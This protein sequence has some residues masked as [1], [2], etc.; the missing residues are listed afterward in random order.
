LPD[1]GR[2]LVALKGRGTGTDYT[3]SQKSAFVT[4]GLMVDLSRNAV[5]TLPALKSLMRRAC[6][7]GYN[8]VGLYTEDTYEVEGRPYFGYLRGRYSLAD[9]RE[10]DSYAASLGLELVPFVQTLAHLNALTKW[11]AFGGLFDINDILLCGSEEVYG[12]VED[13]FKSLRK[14]YSGNR[15]NV[16]M[17]EAHLAGLG[18]YLDAHGYENRFSI[19]IKHLNRVVGLAHK[20]GFD[21]SIW[22]DMFFR[23]CN[24]GNYYGENPVPQ[25]VI[26]QIPK[27][28]DLVYWDYHGTEKPR[29]ERMLAQHKRFPG[30]T[31]CANQVWKCLGLAPNHDWTM[32][33]MDAFLPAQTEAGVRHTV[34]CLWNDNGAAC[35]EFSALPALAY[36]AAKAYGEDGTDKLETDFFALTGITFKDFLKTEL[37]NRLGGIVPDREC[38]SKY[39]FYNDLFCGFLD[40]LCKPEYKASAAEA[41]ELLAPLEHNKKY[42]YIFKTLAALCGVLEVRLGL[43]I[44]TREAYREGDKARLAMLANCDYALLIKRLE[45]FYRV[46][47][48]QWT[49]DN[50]PFGF[51]VHDLRLGGLLQRVKACR[52]RLLLYVNGKSERIDELEQE[53]LPYPGERG[54]DADKHIVLYNWHN[55]VSVNVI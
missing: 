8:T 33:T 34:C 3:V 15:I 41:A 54:F 13:M 44:A 16:G 48:A 37:P 12:L 40:P 14:C 5:M 2:A 30:E 50:K 11:Q 20:Y 42:G 26:D 55:Y 23:L 43:G 17:D 46:F 6:L 19:M 1:L 39:F 4:L 51:E 28:V 7:M 29:Y 31:W 18:K 25:E 52:Q 22:S 53:L 10:L 45:R 35:S 24:G 47:Y 38:P 36:M 9:I 32:R 27:G 21:P 49:A